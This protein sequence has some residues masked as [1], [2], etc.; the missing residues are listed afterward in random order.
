MRISH[1]IPAHSPKFCASESRR[2]FG[3]VRPLFWV[4]IVLLG[5][6]LPVWGQSPMHDANTIGVFRAN[7]ADHLGYWYVDSDDNLTYDSG[8]AGPMIF[9]QTGD[10]PIMGNW[11]G[12][13]TN[14]MQM[15]VFRNG[16]WYVDWDDR[17]GFDSIDG[18]YIF[19]FG[20]PGDIPVVGDWDHT[21]V[22]R[23]G[24]FRNGTWYVNL[25]TCNQLNTLGTSACNYDPNP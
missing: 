2:H 6:S 1:T 23:N 3:L 9:G 22:L 4:L 8:D 18:Q 17:K 15:G 11:T 16:Y 25:K 19:N 21:G 12:S 10:L 13:A 24:I 14:H 7:G 5:C 20:M